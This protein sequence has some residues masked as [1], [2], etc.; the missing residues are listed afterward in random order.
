M[1]RTDVLVIGSGIAGLSF[2]AKVAQRF[3]AMEITVITKDKFSESNTR[4][5]QGGIAVALDSVKDSFQQH[6]E[7]TLLAGDGLCDR[8]VVESVVHEG[9]DRLRELMDWGAQFDRDATG[10]LALGREGGHTAH[11]IIHYKDATGFQIAEAL[12]LYLTTL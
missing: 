11:R 5:A 4:Y 9:P 3:P 7:D 8:K 12:Q 1:V 6:I 2:A 10:H